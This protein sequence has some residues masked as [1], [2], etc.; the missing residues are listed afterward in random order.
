ML[1]GIY[2]FLR[3]IMDDRTP[4]TGDAELILNGVNIVKL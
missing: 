3:N 1:Y 4:V 2:A